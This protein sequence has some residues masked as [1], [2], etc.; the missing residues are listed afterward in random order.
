MSTADHTLP[1][2]SG[3]TGASGEQ[4]TETDMQD[5]DLFEGAVLRSA[6]DG[7]IIADQDGRI[8]E[9]NPAAETI[10]GYTRANI[11]GKTLTETIIPPAREAHNRGVAHYLA[12]GEEPLLGKRIEIT[13]VRADGTELPVALS[14][15]PARVHGHPA[16]MVTS[17]SRPITRTA[18]LVSSRR[19]VTL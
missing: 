8:V 13:A 16:F 17:R 7:I 1:G 14:I 11:I 4:P 10:F 5:A 3:G 15:T 18:R 2:A 6:M 9:F 12:T 19:M